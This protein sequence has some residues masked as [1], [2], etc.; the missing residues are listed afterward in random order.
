MSQDEVAAEAGLTRQTIARLE[1]DA[2]SAQL[3]TLRDVQRVF[4]K[5]GI[6]FLFANERGV[7][8]SFAP[9]VQLKRE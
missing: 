1:Q 6:R 7:G 9:P 2:S 4:E 3:R 5:R 8:I